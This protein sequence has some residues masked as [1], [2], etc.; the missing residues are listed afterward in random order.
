MKS[1][2]ML[3]TVSLLALGMAACSPSKPAANASADAA[4]SAAVSETAAAVDDTAADDV[5]AARPQWRSSGHPIAL[6]YLADSHT[7]HL[8]RRARPPRL[9][10]AIALRSPA[11]SRGR[12]QT[13]SEGGRR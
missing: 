6:G 9:P 5:A 13:E 11:R 4:S 7:A 1:C 3:M 2:A 8:F 10:G 12:V